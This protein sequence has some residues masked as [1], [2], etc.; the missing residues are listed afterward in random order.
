MAL[1]TQ[2]DANNA[3]IAKA[4]VGFLDNLRA[5]EVISP[6]AK[7]E[8]FAGLRETNE[9]FRVSSERVLALYEAGRI[10][11][12]LELHMADEHAISHEIEPAIRE[13]V[14]EA[15][16]ETAE[17]SAAFDSDK[18]FLRVIVLS[19]SGAS[20]VLAVLL[21]F[22]LSLAFIRPVRQISYVLARVADGDFSKRVDVLNR[23]E[24]GSLGR[25][26]NRMSQRL[27]DMYEDLRRELSERKHAEER[28]ERRAIELVAV[29]NELEAFS[30]SVS[31]DLLVPLRTID[32][33]SQAILDYDVDNLGQE[34]T[35]DL[36]RVRTATR[37]MGELID[38][39]MNVS[40]V[41]SMSS[42]ISTELDR[43]A[44][45]LSGLARTVA[46]ELTELEPER[47]V[48]FVIEAGLTANADPQRLR[49]TLESLL[50][51]SWKFTGK[52]PRAKIEFG[53]T[54]REG[55]VAYFVRD[56]GAGFDMAE[57]DRLFGPFSR[58]H[59]STDFEGVGIGLA[60]VQ[61]IVQAHGGRVWA[62]GAIEEG[63][64]F[65]FTLG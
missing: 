60:T 12:A 32:R 64:T 40:R 8:F 42:A 47:R 15:S 26:V 25:N 49:I 11:D 21:G 28:L 35:V 33:I 22:V 4:K 17:A 57:V 16:A 62:E 61:R 36:Q 24:F 14:A 52:H 6:D 41:H 50:G 13:L 20:L 63:A 3:K 45:D 30:H 7:L 46:S 54:D 19:F 48:E 34:G 65:Y 56:D 58:L 39:M 37:R 2:D 51:N 1:L 59:S 55:H 53:A 23:D 5:V 43:K 38:D 44:V 10:D 9:R 29:N 18:S 27:D 31:H